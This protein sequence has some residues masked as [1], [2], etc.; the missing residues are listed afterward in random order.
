MAQKH[1]KGS[2]MLK[3]IKNIFMLLLDILVVPHGVEADT[4]LVDTST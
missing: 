4:T 3:V 1:T 2:A